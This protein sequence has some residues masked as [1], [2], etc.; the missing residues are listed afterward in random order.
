[1]T[2]FYNEEKIN[3]IIELYKKNRE[4]DRKKYEKKKDDP[5]FIQQNRARAKAHYE[6]HYKD[7]KKDKYIKNQDFIK[8]KSLFYYY[9]RT[10]RIDEFKIKF[11]DKVQLMETHG[12]VVGS[13]SG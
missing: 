1:M 10:N 12:F 8:A 13:D 5:A 3:K 9:R 6:A 11:P 4:R 2:D 7:V